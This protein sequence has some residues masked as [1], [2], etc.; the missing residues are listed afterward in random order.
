[1]G[2]LDELDIIP[3]IDR[4]QVEN[5]LKHIFK[6]MSLEQFSKLFINE[7]DAIIEYWKL[8]NGE[9]TGKN[10]SLLFNPHRLD[11]KAKGFQRINL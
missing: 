4:S 5:I 10:I 7:F 3:K 8:Y 11:T 2:F 6:G 1:M 9:N